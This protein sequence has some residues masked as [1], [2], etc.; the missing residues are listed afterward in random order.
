MP[1]KNTTHDRT[2]IHS[3]QEEKTRRK[4]QCTWKSLAFPPPD[5][6]KAQTQQHQKE[7]NKAPAK[8]SSAAQR[9]ATLEIN[10]K[11]QSISFATKK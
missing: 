7:K 4:C 2:S 10:T 9:Q 3:Q 1:A 8:A 6:L 5:L 11:H